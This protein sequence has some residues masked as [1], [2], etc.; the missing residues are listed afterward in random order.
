MAL[1]EVGYV[2][3]VFAAFDLVQHPSGVEPV[4]MITLLDSE[5]AEFL[6]QVGGERGGVLEGEDEFG[7]YAEERVVE[8]LRR[9]VLSGLAEEIGAERVYAEEDQPLVQAVVFGHFGREVEEV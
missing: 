7:I 8:R 5:T 9:F 1:Q 4:P 3:E 2:S 6:A